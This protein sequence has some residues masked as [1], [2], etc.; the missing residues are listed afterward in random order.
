MD[1]VIKN[2]G[3]ALNF[4][5]NYQQ[6]GAIASNF[7]QDNINYVKLNPVEYQ[8][9]HIAAAAAAAAASATNPPP[10]ILSNN[11]IQQSSSPNPAILNSIIGGTTTGTTTNVITVAQQHKCS[12]CDKTFVDDNR[13]MIHMK[14]HSDK[15]PTSF[16]C[17]ICFKTFSQQGNL[18]THY[19]I[20]SGQ[21][22][23]TCDL[24]TKDFRQLSGLKA[25]Q[26]TH[27]DFRPYKCQ[28]CIMEFHQSSAL[29]AHKCPNKIEPTTSA[30]HHHIGGVG[31]GTTVNEMENMMA[32]KM[33]QRLPGGEKSL[34]RKPT[35]SKRQQIDEQ[36]P[37]RVVKIEYNPE[38]GN[39]SFNCDRCSRKFKRRDHL[40][41]HMLIHTNTAQFFECSMCD[42][43]FVQLGNL[44]THLRV[45]SGEKP[46]QCSYCQKG[47]RQLS[48]L[49]THERIHSDEKPFQCISCD[50]RFRQLSGLNSHI[51]HCKQLMKNF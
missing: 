4:F 31:I 11:L 21:K 2:D 39:L 30:D 23:Y 25:H 9:K 26:R 27:L 49:I 13:L 35:K 17:T 36:N 48:G 6:I 28:S 24:C 38:D 7:I 15:K 12:I 50:R 20:H 19:R 45:H 3:S 41:I 47:F 40:D 14:R 43:K 44:K 8:N 42:K 10:S 34:T 22:P 16:E 33:L 5:P 1:L 18:K 51:S 29:R 32:Y 46:Y 37:N